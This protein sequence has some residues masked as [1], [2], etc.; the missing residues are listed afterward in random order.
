MIVK[1]IT[2]KEAEEVIFDPEIYNRI[3]VGQ[4]EVELPTLENVI[5]VGGYCNKKLIGVTV[6]YYREKFTT[7]HIHVLKKYRGKYGV[8]FGKKCLKKQG[9][10]ILYTNIPNKFKDVARFAKYFNFKAVA[11]RNGSTLYKRG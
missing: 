5:Y 8:L 4:G 1:G 2:A 9:E 10:S 6:F 7:I 11:S 3:K